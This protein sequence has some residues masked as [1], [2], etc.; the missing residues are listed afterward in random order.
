MKTFQYERPAD[1]DTAVALLADAPTGAYLGGGTNLVD[2]MKLGVA[3]PDLLVDVSRLPFDAVEETGT[4]GLRIGAAVRNSTLAVHPLVRERYP[5]LSQALLSG[6]STQLRN[7]ATVGGNLLQRTRCPYFQD[8]GKPCN[9]RRPGTGCPAR[10]GA[11]RDLAVLGASEHCVATN[12]SDMAVALAAL[13]AIVDVASGHGPRRVPLTDLHRLPGDAPDRDTTLRHG[14]LITAVELPPPMPGARS[15]YRKARDRASY[16]FALASVGAVLQVREGLVHHV[17]VA[18]G[19]LAA[20]PWRAR[21]AEEALLGEPATTASFD[22]AVR[23]ELAAARPLRDNGY[24]VPLARRMAVSML[25]EL[26]AASAGGT[27]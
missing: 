2:L 5:V 22:D 27:P 19:A 1:A 24:K 18:F 13:D 7:A 9:K 21:T 23:H 4:G 17:R 26:A 20:K 10:E 6:A 16:A 25:T 15:A 12:P 3:A 11:H 14:E 8:V